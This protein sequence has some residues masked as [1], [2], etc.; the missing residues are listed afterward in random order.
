MVDYHSLIFFLRKRRDHV[1][2]DSIEPIIKLHV[3]CPMRDETKEIKA[4]KKI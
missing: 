4:K 3:A 2:S 1:P